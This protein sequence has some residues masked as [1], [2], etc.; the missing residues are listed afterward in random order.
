[1]ENN[2]RVYTEATPRLKELHKAYGGSKSGGGA[3]DFATYFD[4][5]D[6]DDNSGNFCAAT[7]RTNYYWENRGYKHLT[8]QEFIDFMDLGELDDKLKLSEAYINNRD[9]NEDIV[10][11][12]SHYTSGTIEPIDY[13][14]A[15]NMNFC[16]G[17]VIK[18]VTRYKLKN[19]LEDL[20]KAQFYINKLIEGYEK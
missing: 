14:A 18:Y 4:N 2:V 5:T 12:P 20:K 15:N 10:N 19:G 6:T 1:M 8:E 11:K 9:K 7:A 17:N 3:I 16:E 13:I